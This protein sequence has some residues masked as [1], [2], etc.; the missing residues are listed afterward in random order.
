MHS[1]PRSSLVHTTT[2]QRPRCMLAE[3]CVEPAS[4]ER[5]EAP[6]I[7]HDC[8]HYAGS[9]KQIL[10][11]G[12]GT[13]AGRAVYSLSGDCFHSSSTPMRKISSGVFRT[14]GHCS[15][16]LTSSYVSRSLKESMRVL[17]LLA[18]GHTSYVR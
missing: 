1:P 6:I 10:T 15:S 4:A 7:T 14:L 16:I 12:H 2:L 13:I 17:V 18:T 5:S 8:F 11:M 9:G 3:L